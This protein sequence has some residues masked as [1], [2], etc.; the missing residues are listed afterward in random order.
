MD[1]FEKEKTTRRMFVKEIAGAAICGACLGLEAAATPLWIPGQN[2]G[3][4][5]KTQAAGTGRENLVAVCGLN[6]GA[7]PMYLATQSNDE[8]KR[9]ALLK[10]FS[11]G[12]M[13]L[14]MENLL[15][16]GCLGNGRVASFCRKCAIR[17]CPNGKPNVTRCSDCPDFACS[18]ITDF[19]NDGMLHHAEVLDNLRRIQEMGI[20]EWAKYDEERWRCTRCRLPMSWY[21]S[22]CSNCG[23]ARSERLFKL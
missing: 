16:D 14:S 6:C 7:C 17:A 13:K 8:Q 23:E 3:E 15:C 20:H 5:E 21:D 18:R 12:S 1:S 9:S 4:G 2:A 22:K 10:Q 11:S 19:N